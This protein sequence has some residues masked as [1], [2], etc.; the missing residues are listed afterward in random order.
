MMVHFKYKIVL[1]A[2]FYHLIEILRYDHL[3]SKKHYNEALNIQNF[4]FTGRASKF[5]KKANQYKRLIFE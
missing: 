3:S 1:K 4:N 5:M 2:L